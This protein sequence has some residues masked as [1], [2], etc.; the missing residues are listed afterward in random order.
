MT[1]DNNRFSGV[2]PRTCPPASTPCAIKI[3]APARCAV[4]SLLRRPHLVDHENACVAETFHHTW[5]KLPERR[6]NRHSKVN[7]HVKLT[8]EQLAVGGGGDEVYPEPPRDVARRT[9]S[10]SLTD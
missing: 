6:D 5:N 7:A 8:F 4:F 1:S 10:T 9:V 2:V 3:C